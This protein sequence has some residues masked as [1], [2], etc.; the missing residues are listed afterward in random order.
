MNKNLLA[1]YTNNDEEYEISTMSLLMSN[2][3]QGMNHIFW[4]NKVKTIKDPCRINFKELKSKRVTGAFF[5]IYF[6]K[7]ASP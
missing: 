2:C 4:C 1:C 6:F 7:V 3:E 5:D